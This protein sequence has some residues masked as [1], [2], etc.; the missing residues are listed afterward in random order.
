[1]EHSALYLQHEELLNQAIEALG[2][3]QFFSPYPEHPKAYD[4]ELDAKGKDAFGRLLNENFTQLNQEADT[5]VG[6][7]VS[8]L[9]QYGIGVRYPSISPEKYISNS[10]TAAKDW[11]KASIETRAAILI[12]SLERVRGRF[13]ELAYATMHTTG[14]SFMMAFQASGPHAA[15]RALEVVAMGVQELTRYPKELAF[16]KPLGKYSLDVQKSWKPISKGVGLVIGCSTFPTWN[17][18]PGV[19][20]N[21]ICGNTAIIKPHPKSILAI[22]IFL[23]ELRKVLV[24]QGFDANVVQLAADT[25]ANP[26]TVALAENAEVKLIDYTGGCSFGD[27]VE[28]LNKT[29]FTEKSGINSVIIDSV[30]DIKAVAQNI[31]FSISLYSG[32]M[33]T[34]PQNIFIAEE[35]EIEGG[36]LS[37][38]EVASEIVKAVKGVIS[39][40][41]MGAGTLGNVQNDA[42]IK[43][44]NKVKGNILLAPQ[45]VENPEAPNARIQS[46]T[47]IATEASANLYRDECFGPMVFLVKTENTIESVALASELAAQKGAIT[48]LAFCTDADTQEFI[49]EQMNGVF[50][51]VSFNLT[52]AGFVNQHAA[53]SD[54]HVTG[55]NPAGNAT[56]AD[57]SFINRRF[58]WVGNR[59]MG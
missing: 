45:K 41:K 7:E 32:Q 4:Q 18:V 1:M 55:G 46:P 28:T 42:T 26:I 53:F 23:T 2:T 10:I 34:A 48:C 33:C 47:L 24:K 3:R 57:A 40:P 37:F 5:W 43:R 59:R 21:L 12:E 16:S 14:Q 9:W 49:E 39:H 11:K 31:A 22:A 30:N 6:E 44:I 25:L 19:Y 17:T 56:F 54:F 58:V 20:A 27:Y 50:V 38:D 36:V 29:V 15:D 52:G 35:I 13:F 8:P 51:P